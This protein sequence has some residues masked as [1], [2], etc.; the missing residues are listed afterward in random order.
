MMEVYLASVNVLRAYYVGLVVL[1]TTAGL[2]CGGGSGG[3]SGGRSWGYGNRVHQLTEEAIAP[4]TPTYI[5]VPH[6]A[7]LHTIGANSTKCTAA[8]K[9]MWNIKIVKTVAINLPNVNKMV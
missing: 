4:M 1:V 8:E 9:L 7:A 6:V 5:G 2:T 3:G